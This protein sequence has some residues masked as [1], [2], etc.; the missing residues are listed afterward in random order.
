M[1]VVGSFHL[2][3]S[4]LQCSICASKVSLSAFLAELQVHSKTLSTFGVHQMEALHTLL[5]HHVV[6]VAAVSA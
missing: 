2:L 1:M 5:A 6:L 3:L 4:E